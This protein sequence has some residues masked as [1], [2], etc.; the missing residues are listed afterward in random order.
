MSVNVPSDLDVCSVSRTTWLSSPTPSVLSRSSR[1]KTSQ[2]VSTANA[3][4]FVQYA[5]LYSRNKF[6]PGLFVESLPQWPVLYFRVLSLDSWQ[7]YRTEG[8]G[9]LVI[10]AT[11]GKT[12]IILS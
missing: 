1:K 8:Y 4:S 7:R 2:K 10:P 6:C 9:Y 3:A 11:P 12:S 5:R